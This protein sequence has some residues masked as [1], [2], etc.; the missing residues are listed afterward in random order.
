M[1]I[2]L[3][4]KPLKRSLDLEV[5]SS[6]SGLRSMFSVFHLEHLQVPQNRKGSVCGFLLLFQLLPFKGDAKFSCSTF[7][8]SSS[9]RNPP[10][11]A[12]SDWK[13]SSFP[14][15][16]LAHHITGRCLLPIDSPNSSG[17]VSYNI[18]CHNHSRSFTSSILRSV[19]STFSMLKE[20]PASA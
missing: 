4:T 20:A 10:P 14:T 16:R 11:A 5:S 3:Q 6:S 1:E 12:A 9:S 15:I 19:L 7:T 8:G 13:V 17:N 2:N 18:F